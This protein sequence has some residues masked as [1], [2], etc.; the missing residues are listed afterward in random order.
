[1]MH[2]RT[3]GPRA[4]DARTARTSGPKRTDAGSSCPRS[5][6]ARTSG[7]RVNASGRG[8]W[9]VHPRA[10]RSGFLQ[11]GAI[12]RRF[13]HPR[14]RGCGMTPALES[15][16]PTYPLAMMVLIIKLLVITLTNTMAAPIGI[17]LFKTLPV[18]GIAFIPGIPLRR[19]PGRRSHDI[20]RRISIIRGPAIFIAEKVIQYSM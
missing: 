5:M 12:G 6:N 17:L 2:S 10:G 3:R 15:L 19:V 13:M 14:A 1:M 16:M 9:G 4:T 11:S 18:M 8:S 7:S 20:D